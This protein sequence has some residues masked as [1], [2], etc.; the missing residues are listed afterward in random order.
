MTTRPSAP[1]HPPAPD[2]AHTAALRHA[3]L[4]L[5]IA[6]HSLS[7]DDRRRIQHPLT[8][9]V[10][11]FGRNWAS[12]AQLTALCAHIKD[13][14]PDVLIAVDHEGGRVQRFRTDGFTHLP[15]MR[16]LGQLW[17]QGDANQPGSGVLKACEAAT[18]VGHVLA[19][20][21]RACGVDLSFA[22]V[23]D[24]D[25]SDAPDPA[26]TADAA[27]R[28]RS[29]VIGDRSFGRDPRM[30]S[31]LARSLILGLLQA[32]MGHCAKHFPGHGAVQAD[33][34]VALPID[35]RSLRTILADD[36]QPYTWLGSA[37]QAVMPAHVIYSRVD[38]CPAGFS[39]RWIEGIL[40]QQMGFTGLVCT[41]DL[42][43]AA[44]R[45]MDGQPL[46]HAEA[47]LAALHA[48]CDLALL[49]NQS[50]VQNGQPLDTLLDALQHAHHSGHWQPSAQSE[51]R[52]RA[53]LPTR[54]ALPWDE[55]MRSPAY[56]QARQRVSQLAVQ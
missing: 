40:R 32:G 34:H 55:L 49:C 15:P 22:P 1:S 36:A 10:V 45:Q 16:A 19:S 21:L 25:H 28:S 7:N 26:S 51:A 46:S 23:L 52:R 42:S 13:L 39:R 17:A 33:S 41:D 53:L 56:T 8:G 20:E 9:G 6:G 14:R 38:N 29:S 18:S 12:R 48:G 30:V 24:L 2:A 3:P 5:D 37:L 43:M 4:M 54:A 47:V 31:V 44:A 11:L 35:R 27:P 50:I